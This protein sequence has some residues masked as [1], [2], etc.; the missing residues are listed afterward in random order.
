[1]ICHSCGVEA[2]TRFVSFRQSVALVLTR[3]DSRAEGDFCRTCLARHFTRSLGRS[4]ALGWWG[5]DAPF[6]M[7]GVILGNVAEYWRHRKLDPVPADAA[8]PVL[9]DT[10]LARLQPRTAEIV[11]RMNNREPLERVAAVVAR[12]CDVSPG[13]VELYVGELT[14]SGLIRQIW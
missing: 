1:V 11:T 7:P 3:R 6:V 14:R 5:L 2:P 9:D 10:A 13:Q 4:L 8:P 12:R